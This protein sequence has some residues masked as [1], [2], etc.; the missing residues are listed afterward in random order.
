M[1]SNRQNS[2]LLRTL[3]NMLCAL[4]LAGCTGLYAPQK[5]SP[6]IYTLDSSAP[7]KTSQEKRDLVLAVSVPRARPGFDTSRMA[8]LRQPH[9]LDY[10]AVNRW[11]DTPARMLGPL[12]AQAL[13]QTGSF[14]AV[15]LAP[16]SVPADIRLDTELIRLQQDFATRPSKVQFTLRAQLTDMIHKQVLA[17][18]V[19]DE[20]E[21]AAGDDAYGGVI[22]A[23]KLLQRVLD[24]VSDFCIEQSRTLP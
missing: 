15:V 11:A 8:Y 21:D 22:A 13:E 2:N 1:N 23:N 14:R 6:H 19:F 3:R 20:T 17:V 4:L 12:L 10:Y 7:V 18:K 24:Q 5:E 9:E 16:G